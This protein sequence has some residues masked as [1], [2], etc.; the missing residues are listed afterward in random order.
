MLDELLANYSGKFHPVVPFDTEKDKVT[1]LNLSGTNTSL[2]PEIF[3]D[4]ILFSQFI[5][6]LL[7]QA[8]ARYGIGGYLENRKVYARSRVFDAASQDEEPRTL[9]LGIDIWGQSGTQVMA[10]LDG[11]VHSTGNHSEYGNYGATIILKHLLE[12]TTFYTLYGHLSFADLVLKPGQT[13][14]AGEVIAHFGE[15]EEN[16][17][18]PPHLHFQVMTDM[19]GFSGD[20]PGVCAPSS[21]NAFISNCPDPMLI[22]KF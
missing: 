22:L 19:Q 13:V 3:G 16:G 18:W 7:L 5:D 14:T 11:M 10:P 12:G 17:H 20:Y 21:V 8:N 9:H 6:H 4:T 2:T 1:A 15:P